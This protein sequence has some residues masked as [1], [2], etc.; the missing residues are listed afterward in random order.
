MQTLWNILHSLTA[1]FKLEVKERIQTKR[2]MVRD[3]CLD[4]MTFRGPF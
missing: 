4:Q 2:L 3:A 1:F